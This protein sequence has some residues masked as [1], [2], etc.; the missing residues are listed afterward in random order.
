M[1]GHRVYDS[2]N[3][4]DVLTRVR[5]EYSR[6]LANKQSNLHIFESLETAERANKSVF[7]TGSAL[8][9]DTQRAEVHIYPNKNYKQYQRLRCARQTFPSDSPVNICVGSPM[10]SEC[11][12]F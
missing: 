8:K 5:V 7:A 6:D 11:S 3:V 4:C 12:F 1:R 2:V 10:F 9:T